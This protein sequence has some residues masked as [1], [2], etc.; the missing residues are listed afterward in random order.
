MLSDIF[1]RQERKWS[2]EHEII[3]RKKPQKI[4]YN[5]EIIE[6]NILLIPGYEY[7][8]QTKMQCR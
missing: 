4:P 1:L 7:S 2:A 3:L 5:Y 6:E 8:K